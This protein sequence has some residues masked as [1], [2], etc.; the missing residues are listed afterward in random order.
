MSSDRVSGFNF[1]PQIKYN[2]GPMLGMKS[3]RLDV[4]MEYVYWKNKFGQSGQDE[5][6]AN[7][8]VKWHF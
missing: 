7:L 8:L 2:I 5:K 4:G 6:N 1:T 3:G